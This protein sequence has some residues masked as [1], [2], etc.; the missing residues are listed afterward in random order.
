MNSVACNI[1]YTDDDQDDQDIFVDAAHEVSASLQVMIQGSG[2]ELIS[3]LKN[4]PPLPDIIFL[5]LNMPVKNGYEVLKEIKQSIN[6]KH[7][8]VVIFSTSDD[9]NA[10]KT[11]RQL[12]ASLY[13]T[14]PSSFSSLKS[15][16][17]HTLSINWETF[18]ASED[19]YV[20]RV[21]N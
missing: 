19:D 1:F 14:K 2:H 13:I 10:I 7:I 17:K 21:N 6:I 15:A 11:T 20:Y 8:P 5:D 3:R 9:A 18:A 4:P 16:I 12:G